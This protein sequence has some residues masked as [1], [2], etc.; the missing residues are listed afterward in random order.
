MNTERAAQILHSAEI[1]EVT[2]QNTPV[3]IEDVK[4]QNNSAVVKNLSTDEVQE[5]P[6]A[7]LQE[8]Q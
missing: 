2:Y 6:V 7:Q 8:R 5:V 1:I 4:K 3:W